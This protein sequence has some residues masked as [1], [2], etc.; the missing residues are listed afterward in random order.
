MA[1]IAVFPF[2]EN[3][4]LADK[5]CE[6]KD[7]IIT[8]DDKLII[9]T[10]NINITF[11]EEDYIDSAKKPAKRIKKTIDMIISGEQYVLDKNVFKYIINIGCYSPSNYN[12][13]NF[14]IQGC[15]SIF[16]GDLN[17][18]PNTNGAKIPNPSY[19]INDI[20]DCGFFEDYMQK[21][22]NSKIKVNYNRSISVLYRNY[23]QKYDANIRLQEN[24]LRQIEAKDTQIK[25]MQETIN[26]LRKELA[27]SKLA[28][29]NAISKI[30][31]DEFDKKI[32]PINE[33]LKQLWVAIA[34]MKSCNSG[35]F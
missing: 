29:K 23:G 34:N 18:F 30:Q 19:T 32:Q 16:S 33:E 8:N 28:E 7:C 20:T 9:R 2:S 22:D 11:I 24:N 27:D 3:Y 35:N 1:A 10:T 17:C 13:H 31:E 21:L 14:R 4:N 25:Q 12:Q 15:T 26:Q 5:S 6:I